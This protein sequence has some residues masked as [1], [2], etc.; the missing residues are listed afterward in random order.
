MNRIAICYILMSYLLSYSKLI[1]MKWYTDIWIWSAEVLQSETAN[2]GNHRFN[3]SHHP[4]SSALSASAACP[5][6]VACEDGSEFDVH[7]LQTQKG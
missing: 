2:F 3:S 5:D 6:G 1:V 4:T 7:L